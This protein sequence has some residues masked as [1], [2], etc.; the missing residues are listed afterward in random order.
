MTIKEEYN[1]AR[2]NALDYDSLIDMCTNIDAM[3]GCWG[4]EHWTEHDGRSLGCRVH[5]SN[6]D[7]GIF[8]EK[9]LMESDLAFFTRSKAWIYIEGD[10]NCELCS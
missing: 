8:N 7:N 5:E 3:I 6:F 10:E 4:C 9:V 2:I 1:I